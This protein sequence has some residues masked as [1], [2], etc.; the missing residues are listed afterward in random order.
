MEAVEIEWYSA[1]CDGLRCADH[2]PKEMAGP[3]AALVVQLDS[4]SWRL[5]S[6]YRNLSLRAKSAL[7]ELMIIV[8]D[9]PDA[10]AAALAREIV[11]VPWDSV[12]RDW[13]D[14]EKRRAFLYHAQQLLECLPDE[15]WRQG[16]IGQKRF[17]GLVVL[18]IGE[19]H[20]GEPRFTTGTHDARWRALLVTSLAKQFG[21][22]N[23]TP[24]GRPGANQIAAAVSKVVEGDDV[25]ENTIASYV[26]RAKKD[27]E[28]QVG[29]ESLQGILSGPDESEIQLPLSKR[30]TTLRERYERLSQRYDE[31]LRSRA[32]LGA[33][34]A[35]P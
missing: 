13:T 26:S 28:Q 16:L 6:D 33:S 29:V 3:L 9:P 34:Y 14:D 27:L 30:L 22:R 25:S 4:E 35:A 31:A 24:T 2:I 32:S 15:S 19:E 18:R 5:P 7:E 10:L 21:Y 11:D 20:E 1:V 23:R 12:R 17:G 8:R